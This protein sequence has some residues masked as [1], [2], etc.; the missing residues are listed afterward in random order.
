MRSRTSSLVDA[1]A[2]AA[3][4]A[5]ACVAVRALLGFD[6]VSDDDFT[7]VTFAQAFAHA[8]RLDPS[9]SSWLPFPF[10]VLGGAMAL[11]GRSLAVAHAV[12]I[13]V[14]SAAATLPYVALRRAGS[15]RW[16]ALAATAF[17]LS[18]PWSL[19]LGAATV[20]E[21]MTASAVAAAAIALSARREGQGEGHDQA[22]GEAAR[23]S[24]AEHLAT[25]TR[26][27]AA[28]LAL[29]GVVLACACLSR[30]EAWPVAAVLAVVLARRAWAS[31]T[32]PLR[33][34]P[35][36]VVALL[37]AMGPLAWMAW[38]AHAHDGPLHFFRRVS[39]FRRAGGGGS[40]DIVA[41][42]LFYPRLLAATRPDV[43]ALSLVALAFVQ[44]ARSLARRWLVPLVCAGAGL[45]FLAVGNTRD[46]APTHHE[47]RALLATLVLLALSSA[48]AVL[49][50]APR[51]TG[52]VR[53][54]VIGAGAVVVAAWLVAARA[55]FAP[56]PGSDP[57]GDRRIQL[58]RGRAL[59]LTSPAGL[60]VEPCAFEHFALVAA[61]GAPERVEVLP[62][63][64][65][66]VT[67]SCPRV[68][69][70]ERVE[71]VETR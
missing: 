23:R 47:E 59:A 62:R 2:I 37:A 12:S 48:D 40:T 10:W 52:R 11:L 56:P 57:Q 68:E 16:R 6:H 44:R 42:L 24:H 5:S 39:T 25:T 19:W 66:P 46:G 3:L 33:A 1:A 28:A 64:G 27:E 63:T 26:R 21:S 7:R 38:N 53:L 20:P 50:A 18:S 65:A 45:V 29:W 71:T 41:A 49:D 30:Y 15:P 13:A 55:L 22:R 32:D 54:L 4:H 17:A 60:V 43:A 14:A 58:A 8:P 61:Y 34:R 36:V 51:V 35:L 31:R 67:S 70:V 9:G 69:R